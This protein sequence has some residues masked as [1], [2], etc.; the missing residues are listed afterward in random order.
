MSRALESI[1]SCPAHPEGTAAIRTD[2]GHS[3][4]TDERMPR[5]RR[6]L[7]V[8][9]RDEVYA[10]LKAVLEDEGVAVDRAD[11]GARVANKVRQF[12][13][14]LVLINESL[15]DESGWLVATKI[16]FGRTESRV[17]LYAAEMP[18]TVR[19]WM[20]QSAVAEVIG[21]HGDLLRLL[22][23]VRQR[24]RE[25]IGNKAP[26]TTWPTPSALRPALA[27]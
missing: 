20:L 6:V 12:A 24:T 8:D 9:F 2:S 19:E 27:S 4:A 21:Y 13:P 10:S 17:W 22:T 15:P 25:L 11:C 5:P 23:H 16:R 3:V 18:V 7:I 1:C 14:D 26:E